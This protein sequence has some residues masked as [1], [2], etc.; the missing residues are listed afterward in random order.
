MID[1]AS[2]FPRYTAYEPAVPIWCVTPGDRPAIHR[3][4]DTS[5]VSPSGRY[6]AVTRLPYDDRPPTP[7][8]VAEVLV[9]DLATG[10]ERVVA[11]TRGWDTQL[12]AG[13]QWGADDTA[14]LYNDVDPADWRPYAVVLDPAGG[15][16]RRVDCPVYMVS[17]DG[18]WALSPDLVRIRRA[19]AGYGVIVPERCVPE[20]RGAPEDDGLYVTDLASG[21]CRLLVS[22]R[23]IV[24][25]CAL[26]LADPDGHP[27]DYYGFHAKWNAR[28]DR[29]MFVVR[30][31]PHG[32]GV[33]RRAVV[34]LRPDGSELRVAIS[35][36]TWV[37]GGH[38]PNWLPDGDRV[39]MN[40]NLRGEG[41][42]LASARYDGADL[43]PLT[44][45]VPGSGHPSLH[46]NGRH[47]LTDAYT[48]EPLAYGD[49]TTP[50]RLI[51]VAAGREITLARIRTAPPDEGPVRMWRVDPH[52]AWDRAYRRAVFNAC[53][54]GVRR[55]YLA[56]LSALVAAGEGGR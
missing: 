40:L 11:E 29:I 21:A 23:R 7:G 51:D 10:D 5:P 31:K 38:H 54:G 33:E 22:L 43:A 41:M 3:F 47:V 46:P 6:V 20:N 36:E 8:D 53:P 1:L 14:L 13:V 56:D 37:P 2:R 18:R 28:G 55:V 45:A 17:P 42:R 26:P 35:P 30:G 44:E 19:Q 9:V 50:L 16:T 49:G 27:L 48:H 39:L 15:S 25:E 32:A 12:G 24:E 4:F 34:T 52:P